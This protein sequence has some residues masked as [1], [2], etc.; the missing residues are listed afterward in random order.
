MQDDQQLWAYIARLEQAI[1]ESM[2]RS[3]EIA[4]IVAKLQDK[5]VQVSINCVAQIVT[6]DGVVLKAPGAESEEDFEGIDELLDDDDLDAVPMHLGEDEHAEASDAELR[7][8][9]DDGDR[10]FLDELGLRFD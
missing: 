10:R 5:G 2:E 7:F 8:E 6:P 1:R 4:D 3:D 9:I